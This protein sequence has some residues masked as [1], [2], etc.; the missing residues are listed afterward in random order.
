M[1]EAADGRHR[2]D[3]W[4]WFARLYRSRS[5]AARA[6]GGGRVHVNGARVKPAREVAVG[7]RLDL[8]RGPDA[9]SVIVRALP[10]RRGPAAEAAACYEET[11]ESRERRELSRESRRLERERFVAPPARPDRRDRR[12][13]RRLQGRD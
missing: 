3:R 5:L 2:I 9:I 12:A 8:A 7:D 4:L 1:A 6:V 11:P 10:E 13:I